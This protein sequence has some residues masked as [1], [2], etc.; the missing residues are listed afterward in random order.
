M[1]TVLGAYLSKNGVDVD[2]INHNEKH[3]AGLRAHGAH[4]IGTVDFVQ[5]VHALLPR[6]MTGR[7]D[8]ILL[9]TKQLDNDRIVRGLVPF[10]TADGIV[11]TMQNGMPEPSVA[12]V[13]GADR[14]FGCAVGWGATMVGEGVAELTTVPTPETLAFSLGSLTEKHAAVRDEIARILGLMGK[15]TVEANFL[16]ARWA[17]LLVNSAFSGLST[18]L[19]CTFGEVAANKRSRRVAQRV[20]KECIDVAAAMNVKIEPIQG[21]DVVRLLN[22]RGWLKRQISFMIIPLAIR[23]HRLLKSSML[24]DLERGRPCE[25]DAINGVVCRSGDAADI[26]TPINDMIV[27]IV[28]DIEAG[29]A[30]PEFAN[31]TRFDGLI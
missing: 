20:M 5:P 7:Y 23:K 9:M 31:L 16:G 19:G 8:V 21:K 18:V 10:L 3:V 26:D 2:L 4:V 11:C 25:I 30:H 13:I 29:K 15:V 22:Y 6:E 27:A 28:R 1:G 17:K 12:A 14:T 24:Q